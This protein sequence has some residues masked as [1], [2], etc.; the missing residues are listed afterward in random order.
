MIFLRKLLGFLAA[1]TI[2][3]VCVGW[4]VLMYHL[5]LDKIEM[6]KQYWPHAVIGGVVSIILVLLWG[7]FDAIDFL[8]QSKKR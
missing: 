3:T 8:R 6:W 5:D 7:Y 4:R 1:A 2:I